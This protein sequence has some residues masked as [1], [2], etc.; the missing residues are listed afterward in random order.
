MDSGNKGGLLVANVYELKDEL[1][2]KLERCY[3]I[4]NSLV[5]GLSEREAND[6]LN[7]YVCKGSQNHEEVQL[8]L[9]YAILTAPNPTL[10][11]KNY[12]DIHL[13]NRDGFNTVL[14]RLNQLI[15]EKWLKLKDI[16][17]AQI[18]WLVR[19]MVKNSVTGADLAVNGLMR[20]IAGGDITPK[21]VWLAETLLDV[22]SEY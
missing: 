12:R 8:G 10:A 20:Q 18:L 2:E 1:E 16:G 6:A 21:N 3:G 22:L 15:Y 4:V 7:T 11:Q 17:R 13:V 5:N 19:E 9:F 14:N